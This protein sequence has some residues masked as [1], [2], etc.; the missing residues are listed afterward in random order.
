MADPEDCSKDEMTWITCAASLFWKTELENRPLF[1][2]P[3]PAPPV[4][5]LLN[6]EFGSASAQARG[7]G[8]G[9]L[10]IYDFN[11]LA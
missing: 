8:N 11:K 1:D 5:L 2:A 4:Q 10:F 9:H 7:F 3:L 6:A